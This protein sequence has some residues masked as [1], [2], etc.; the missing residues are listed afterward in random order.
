[1]SRTIVYGDPYWVGME[2]PRINSKGKKVGKGLVQ[3]KCFKRSDDNK[4]KAEQ[5]VKRN[6]N[7]NLINT[8]RGYS[9][10]RE[11]KLKAVKGYC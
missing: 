5:F 3:V 10:K 8:S 6:N 7:K 4:I 11:G 1:M 2:V 9:M